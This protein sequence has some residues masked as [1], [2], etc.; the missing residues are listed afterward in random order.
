MPMR[1]NVPSLNKAISIALA[2]CLSIICWN[3]ISG[4]HR[5][6]DAPHRIPVATLDVAKVFKQYRDFNER[7]IHLKNK[8]EEYDRDIRFRQ[9]QIN[10]KMPSD[11][12]AQQGNEE[13]EK[14]AAYAKAAMTVEVAEKKKEF[15][16]AE[17]RIYADRYQSIENIVSQI[18][19][20]RD[21]GIV[22]RATTDAVSP[23]DRNSVL[24]GVNRPVIYSAVPDLTDDVIAELNR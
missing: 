21:V 7:M 11:G 6:A 3:V 2:T 8:I 14:K 12:D 15:L 9:E 10:K 1:S 4:E 13:A 20:K 16:A 18:C 19:K 22:V 23:T 17:A 5:D 24:Q